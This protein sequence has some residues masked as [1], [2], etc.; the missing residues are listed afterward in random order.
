MNSSNKNQE[1]LISK[2]YL[3]IIMKIYFLDVNNLVNNLV[4]PY[5][6]NLIEVVNTDMDNIEI[7]QV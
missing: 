7:M 5:I 1:I 3:Q 6:S 2:Y 4:N